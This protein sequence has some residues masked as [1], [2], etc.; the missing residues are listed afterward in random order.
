MSEIVYHNLL[1]VSA[2]TS[3]LRGI[4]RRSSIKISTVFTVFPRP[5]VRKTSSISTHRGARISFSTVYIWL[6]VHSWWW[7]TI[8]HGRW[9]IVTTITW[10][11]A[12]MKSGQESAYRFYGSSQQRDTETVQQQYLPSL[13]SVSITIAIPVSIPFPIAISVAFT[14][15]VPVPITFPFSVVTLR[16]WSSWVIIKSISLMLS[17]KSEYRKRSQCTNS[18]RQSYNSVDIH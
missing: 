8:T 17:T 7:C 11:G 18:M 13:I 15:S 14:I 1:L 3:T 9:S 6:R 10:W 12:M 4:R 2:V 16:C 5:P